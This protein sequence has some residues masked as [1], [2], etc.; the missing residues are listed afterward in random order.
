MAATAE[1]LEAVVARL[2][3]LEGLLGVQAAEA[4][5]R[6]TAASTRSATGPPPTPPS[7]PG[8]AGP[9]TPASSWSSGGWRRATGTSRRPRSG[10]TAGRGSARDL[11]LQGFVEQPERGRYAITRRGLRAFLLSCLLPGD[12]RQA[13]PEAVPPDPGEDGAPPPEERR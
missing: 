4:A 1:G 8:C 10:S 7:A 2:E 11:L 6:A 5:G 13:P 3:R 9:S 12:P